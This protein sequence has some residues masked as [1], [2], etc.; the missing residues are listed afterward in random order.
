MDVSDFRLYLAPRVSG[1]SITFGRWM[2][3]ERYAATTIVQYCHYVVRAEGW[4]LAFGVPL[5]RA[6]PETLRA[7]WD[8]LPAGPTTRR[9]ARKA[10]VLFYQ[11]LGKTKN[12]AL[13]IPVVPQ[14]RGKPRPIAS[15]EHLAFIAAAH[16]LGGIHEVVGVLFATTGCRFSELRTA[17]REQF[18]LAAAE[19]RIAGKGSRRSG[20]RARI[21][22]LHGDAVPIVRRW[23]RRTSD[24]LF[25]AEGPSTV[26]FIGER[27]LREVFRAVLDRAGLPRSIVPHRIRHTFA[28][29]AL[30][31]GADLRVVQELMGHESLATT[32]VYTAVT[33]ARMRDAVE[34]MPA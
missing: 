12:P 18:D 28:T 33:P 7:W 13:D 17:R 24:H 6:A 27:R 31:R 29:E 8:T 22:P 30:E 1:V 14:P 5:W 2:S 26:P 19:W 11:S 3:T 10:L 25:V 4:A 21:F 23:L 32:Q 34:S 15:D 20:P 9:N 16:D